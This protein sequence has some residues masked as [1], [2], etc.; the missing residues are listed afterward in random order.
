MYTYKIF[1]ASEL[2]PNYKTGYAI[3]IYKNDEILDTV[4]YKSRKDCITAS[5]SLYTLYEGIT[6][7]FNHK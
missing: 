6:Q 5:G 1:K 3:R 2:N 4:F 7:I